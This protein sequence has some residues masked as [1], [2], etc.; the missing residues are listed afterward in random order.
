MDHKSRLEMAPGWEFKRTPEGEDQFSYK[1]TSILVLYLSVYL[2]YSSPFLGDAQV[3]STG[4]PCVAYEYQ[5]MFLKFHGCSYSG[6][7]GT[8]NSGKKPRTI[9]SE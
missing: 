9:F 8:K 6:S 7:V 5:G 1:V 3:E 2:K 4:K